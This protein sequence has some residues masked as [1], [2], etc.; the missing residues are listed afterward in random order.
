MKNLLL[1]ICFVFVIGCKSGIDNSISFP[2]IPVPKEPYI[3]ITEVDCDSLFGSALKF[4]YEVI[5]ELKDSETV[6]IVLEKHSSKQIKILDSLEVDLKRE[7]YFLFGFIRE[8]NSKGSGI[9]LATR[10]SESGG[11]SGRSLFEPVSGKLNR[12]RLSPANPLGISTEDEVP[13]ATLRFGQLSIKHSGSE[14]SYVTSIPGS[15]NDF[16]RDFIYVFKLKYKG[17][18]YLKRSI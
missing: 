2:D 4:E 16:N 10:I 1:T 11:A 17:N 15:P 3:H 8:N 5:G 12:T 13:L 18:I 7:G 6:S 14:A 9:R